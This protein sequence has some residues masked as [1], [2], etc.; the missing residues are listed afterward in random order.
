MSYSPNYPAP[1]HS[2]GMQPIVLQD[3]FPPPAPPPPPP[4]PAVWRCYK[5]SEED[6]STWICGPEPALAWHHVAFPLHRSHLQSPPLCGPGSVL[7]THVPSHQPQI[8]LHWYQSTDKRALL[9]NFKSVSYR[10]AMPKQTCQI[11]PYL[12]F[13]GIFSPEN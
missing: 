2:Q 1:H 8:P 10:C 5:C 11:V 7:S 4:H 9:I 3:R 12:I 13:M 6:C